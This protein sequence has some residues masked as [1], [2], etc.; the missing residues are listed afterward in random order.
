MYYLQTAYSIAFT[1]WEICT[2]MAQVW[3]FGYGSNIGLQNLE[4][5]GLNPTRCVAGTISGFEL[6]WKQAF[7]PFVEPAWAG[8]RTHPKGEDGELHGTAFLIPEEEAEKL[9]VQE[10]GYN[11]QPS[12]FTS[13]DGEVIE[14][15]GLYVNKSGSQG[16]EEGIPSL[17]YLR[18]MQ[19]GAKE[20]GLSEEW[21]QRLDSTPYYVTPLKVREKTMGWIKEF[22]EDP[23]RKDEMWK[24]EELSKYNGSDEACPVH[25]S[26]MGYIVKANPVQRSFPSWRGHDITRRNLLQFNAKSLDKNDIRY[27]QQGFRPLPKMHCC[28]DEEKEF[29]FQNLDS[30]LHSGGTIA[31]RLKDFTDDQE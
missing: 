13:Y 1:L 31:A 25:I 14:G 12:K 19:R 17:R 23:A 4:K 7:S 27:D 5:K 8:I 9:D 21:I 10:R 6:Y 15:V 28:S 2:K 18:L 26:V 20:A 11:V 3:R 16:G 22:E 30:L 24:S 29:L